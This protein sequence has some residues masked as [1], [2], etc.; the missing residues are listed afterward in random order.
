MGQEFELFFRLSGAEEN[1][2]LVEL[3]HPTA[4]S[5]VVPCVVEGPLCRDSGQDFID[6]QRLNCRR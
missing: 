6:G 2:V 5:N 3:I 4:E 1:R